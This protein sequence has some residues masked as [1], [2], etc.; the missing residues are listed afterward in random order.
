MSIRSASQKPITKKWVFLLIFLLGIALFF[1]PSVRD[2][3]MF[4]VLSTIKNQNLS[5]PDN[6][7]RVAFLESFGWEVKKEPAEIVE[8]VIP[9]KFG[10]VYQN[11]NEIQKKQGFQLEHFRGKQVRRYTYEVT[12]YPGQKKYIR[13]NLLIYKEKVIGGDICS[14]Y[15]KNG[16]MHGFERPQKAESATSSCTAVPASWDNRRPDLPPDGESRPA[17]QSS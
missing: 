11:Y 3:L 17:G 14:I 13:A 8:V 7:S 16:F 1:I 6:Q 5:V 9:Q 2:T 15:A 4:P 12:N 10:Q